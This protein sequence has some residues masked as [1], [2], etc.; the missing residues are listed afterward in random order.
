MDRANGD[1][2]NPAVIDQIFIENYDF[3]IHYLPLPP[4]FILTCDEILI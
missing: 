4:S 3:F 1:H 2:I